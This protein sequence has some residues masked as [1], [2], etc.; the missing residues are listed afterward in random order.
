MA[1]KAQTNDNDGKTQT[2]E[3]AAPVTSASIEL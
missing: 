3:A 2:K 1:A